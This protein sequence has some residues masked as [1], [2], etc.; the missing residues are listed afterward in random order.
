M[1]TR[2]LTFYRKIADTLRERKIPCVVVMPPIHEEVMQHFASHDLQGAYQSWVDEVRAIFPNVVNLTSSP[3]GA[4]SGFYFRDPVH[5]KPEV[6]VSFM[7]DEV[8]PLALKVVG[9]QRK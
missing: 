2:A 8:L 6:G 3:Y 1:M 4:A 9:E 7:N 5:Y